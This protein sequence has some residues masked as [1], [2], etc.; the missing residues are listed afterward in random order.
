MFD[1]LNI[2]YEAEFKW[3]LGKFLIVFLNY[4]FVD[5]DYRQFANQRIYNADECNS[6]IATHC[7]HIALTEPYKTNFYNVVRDK[8]ISHGSHDHPLRGGGKLNPTR[9]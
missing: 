4:G 5:L 9:D 6:Y 7:N 3:I 1:Y 2:V 8:K